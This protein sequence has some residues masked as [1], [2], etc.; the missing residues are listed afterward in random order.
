M[1]KK[2]LV[3]VFVLGLLLL[4]ANIWAAPAPDGARPAKGHPTQNLQML[5][6]DGGT[7]IHIQADTPLASP[8][9][10]CT[11]DWMGA[12]VYRYGGTFCGGE[13]YYCLQDPSLSLPYSWNPAGCG[14]TPYKFNVTAIDM[15]VSKRPTSEG[16]NPYTFPLQPIVFDADLS[17]PGCPVPG[18][19]KCA[20][21]VYAV[22]LVGGATAGITYQLNLPFVIECCVGGPYFGAIYLAGTF[23]CSI[24]QVTVDD[25]TLSGDYG[26]EAPPVPLHCNQYI[27]GDGPPLGLYSWEA[28]WLGTDRNL[29]L[30]TEGYDPGDAAT[31][32]TPGICDYQWWYAGTRQNDDWTNGY[33]LPTATRKKMGVRYVSDGLDTLK[34]VSFLLY[35]PFTSG[36]PDVTVEVWAGDGAGSS[37]ALGNLPGTLL[38]TT[39]V[40]YASLNFY[41]LTTDVTLPDITWGILNGGLPQNIYI[42]ISEASDGVNGVTALAAGGPV[43][44]GCPVDPHSIAFYAPAAPVPGWHYLA[45]IPTAYTQREFWMDAYICKEVVPIVEQ[46]CSPAGPDSW[47]TWAHDYQRTSATSMNL[48]DPCKVREQWST[49][50]P[51]LSSFTNP[52]IANDRVYVSTENEVSAYSLLSGAP[53][54]SVGA[55]PYTGGQVRSNV[56][57]VGDRVFM[58]GGTGL[59]ISCWDL[60]LTTLFWS[61][62]LTGPGL[63]VAGNGPLNAR[64][65][66]GVTA[67]YTVGADSIVVVGTERPGT[68]GNGWLYA[69]DVKTGFLYGGWGTNPMPLDRGSV[70]SPAYDG[71]KLYVG[72]ADFGTNHDGSLYA[73]DAA[74]GA[75]LWNYKD[76]LAPLEGWPGGVSTEGNFLYAATFYSDATL[77]VSSGHRYAINKSGVGPVIAWRFSEGPTLYAAPTIGRNFLYIPQDNPATGLLMIDKALGKAVYNW[78]ADGVGSVPQNVTLTCDKYLF[79]GDRGDGYYGMWWLLDVS[80][81]SAVWRRSFGG[82]VNGTAIAHAST[83]DDYAVV[84]SR[85]S[86][87]GPAG[88]GFLTAWRFNQTDRPFLHQYVYETG[89]IL[90]PLNSGGGLGP[91]TETGVYG[92]DGCVNLNI[93]GTNIL[94]IAP[95]AANYTETQRKY[96]AAYVNR[97]IGSDYVTYFDGGISKAARLAGALTRDAELTAFD[98]PMVKAH[99]EFSA[100]RHSGATAAGAKV[101]ILRT[102]TVTYSANPILPGGVTNMTWNY[103]GTNLGRGVDDEY[104]ETVNDDPDFYPEDMSY[105][106]GM[107]YPANYPILIV[108]YVGGCPEANT[109]LDWNTLGAANQEKVWNHGALGDAKAGALV[110]GAN[111]NDDASNFD[112]GFL[113]LGDSTAAIGGAMLR[114]DYYGFTRMYVPDPRPSDAQCGFEGASDVHLGW[115]MDGPCPGQPVEILGQYVAA[116]Y[117]DTDFFYAPTDPRATLGTSTT[118]I[119]IGAYDPLY[120]DFKLLQWQIHN[121]DAVAKNL[122]AGTYFDWDVVPGSN[123]VGLLSDNFNGYAIWSQPVA[124]YAYGMFNP[125]LRTAYCGVDPTPGSPYKI[126]CNLNDTTYGH[127]PGVWG[128]GSNGTHAVDMAYGWSLATT[129]PFRQYMGAPQGAGG[130]V[131]DRGGFLINQPF[132]LAPQGRYDVEQALY[133]VPATSNDIPTI[134]ALATNVAKRAAR[135]AGYARGDV[136]D[137]GCVNLAD[138]C[139]LNSGLQIYPDTYCGDVNIDGLTNAADAT[140][141]MNYVSGLGPAPLGKWRFTF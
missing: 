130:I 115:R 30:W 121:R 81:Q 31:Q 41:P 21:P 8:G 34:S 3:A 132:T 70:H 13:I 116:F 46:P 97:K 104:I 47:P 90:V 48:G 53:I 98:E 118:Q 66:F 11:G 85:S 50:L 71:S 33:G 17:T 23:A 87:T 95:A 111:G 109:L 12:R 93:T 49:L 113:L 108:H 35:G 26:Q 117:S 18:G 123:N 1:H 114:I 135:W 69:L 131:D 57:V 103:D 58:T 122:K 20:G 138:V 43:T 75:Q 72:T 83:G 63:T 24:A 64:N 107:N 99:Q 37:C 88:E 105:V 80:D 27:Y 4:T 56:S 106:N 52:V 77:G 78:S 14:A 39:T 136:N 79:A 126:L 89:V 91:Y 28:D 141:L 65:R 68:S 73:F 61:N 2:P 54:G 119:E 74:T 139:W 55:F 120:G 32:C 29:R 44:A 129:A 22:T 15:E 19:V 110:W 102:G 38:Y 42:T 94:D 137:D 125:N 6:V 96:A 45:E 82:I 67:V 60:N 9:T 51:N 84:N 134:D 133:A 62:D 100:K 7:P 40:P 128:S 5:P 127:T 25:Q 92:N 101:D 16:P 124:A 59:S 76:G 86:F 140:Y 10:F 112:G 36:A